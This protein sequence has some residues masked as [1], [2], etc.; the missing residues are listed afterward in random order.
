MRAL[1]F[2]I[3]FFS[4]HLS[5]AQDLFGRETLQKPN[6]K[7]QEVNITSQVKGILMV[8]DTDRAVPLVIFIP[9]QGVVDRNGNDMRSKHFA[10]K[11]LA[12]SL[13]TNQIATYRY[14]KRTFTQVKN[15]RVDNNTT[16]EDF[17]ADA[18]KVIAA[19]SNDRRF[20]KI[21]VLGHGQG[22]LVGMLAAIENVD[23][24]ISVAGAADPIDQIIVG[25]IAQQQPGLDKVAKK[26]FDKMRAQEGNVE[27]IQPALQS[28]L[29]PSVQPFIKSWMK[30]D[31]KKVIAELSFP[32]LI[33]HGS[34]DRQIDVVNAQLLA[35]SSDSAEVKVINGMNHIM[36]RVGDDEIL[37]S[38]SYVDPDYE[39]SDSFIET[40][41]Q[42]IDM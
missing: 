36:K 23:K 38:K 33:I 35:D 10:Y 39:L 27:D 17:V 24:F 19:F 21:V 31:P 28:I 6:T 4:I 32:I 42:F 14:D 9:D 41:I 22:S 1:Y 29:H 5:F 26:T 25:Q 34:K 16:L 20:S 30:Y 8:P 2:I 13:L 40:V 11:Q 15:R 18:R 3:L 12:D 7:N 37:A